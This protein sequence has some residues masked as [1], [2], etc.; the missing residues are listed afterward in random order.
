MGLTL[1]TM[2]NIVFNNVHTSSLS[3]TRASSARDRSPMSRL[4]ASHLAALA[5]VTASVCAFSEARAE[6][7][8]SPAPA[9]PAGGGP[10]LELAPEHA[11]S[12]PGAPATLPGTPAP[13][14]NGQGIGAADGSIDLR[15]LNEQRLRRAAESESGT[16]IGGYGEIQLRGTAQGRNAERQWVADISRL[17]LFVSHSFNDSFRFYS[18]LEV[19]HTLSCATCPGEFEVEQAFL[20]WRLLGDALSARAGLVLIPMGIINQWHEPP[21]FNG[22]VRPKVDTVIIPSTWRDL[23]VGF[24]GRPT[25]SLR[26]EAYAVTAL[27]PMKFGSGG[28]SAA[29]EQGAL[30]K[31][32]AFAFVGRLE[33]QPLLGGV[34]G[35]SGYYSDPGE[36]GEFFDAKHTKVDL[37]V[38]VYGWDVDARYG[39]AGFEWRV[40]FADWFLPESN[41]LMLTRNATG[42]LLFDPAHPVPTRMVGGYVEGAYD[43]FHPFGLKHQLLPFARLEHYN[44][45]AAVPDGYQKDQTFNVREYT[46]GLTYRPI[47]QVVLKADYQLRN[48]RVGFDE[49]QLN[50]GLGFMY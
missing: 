42:Q 6:Q 1:K 33:W 48:R 29:R 10:A 34:V 8:S 26:Y 41:A 39:R 18:E 4:F 35:L 27:D 38:P 11:A 19:E 7:P 30:A 28:L 47:R 14:P 37:S 5:F 23:G 44:T 17:V 24:F 25:D 22:V 15:G 2:L 46:F 32:N 36:N 21:I 16:S 40:V 49:T 13:S 31:A 9:G 3:S 20:D 45:Q 12:P 43:V 50:F